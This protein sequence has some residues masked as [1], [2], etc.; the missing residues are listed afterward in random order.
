MNSDEV[1]AILAL[2]E[3]ATPYAKDDDTLA[4]AIA[5]VRQMVPDDEWLQTH[6]EDEIER[7]RRA[8]HA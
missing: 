7:L 8:D 6:V 2:I 4:E 5:S 1:A 3:S